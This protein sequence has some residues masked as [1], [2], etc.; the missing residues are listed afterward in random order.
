MRIEKWEG[1][2]DVHGRF[3]QKMVWRSGLRFLHVRSGGSVAPLQRDGQY[4]I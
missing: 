3:V 1:V 4:L 2:E